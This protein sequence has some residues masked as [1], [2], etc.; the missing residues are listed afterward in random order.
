MEPLYTPLSEKDAELNEILRK[1]KPR[2]LASVSCDQA[3]Q[4]AQALKAVS[5]EDLARIR[6]LPS[7]KAPRW[8]FGVLA[9]I[10]LCVLLALLSERRHSILVWMSACLTFPGIVLFVH[11]NEHRRNIRR[12]RRAASSAPA[13]RTDKLLRGSD[14]CRR[15]RA[16]V[17]ASGR[18]LVRMDFW[19]MRRLAAQDDCGTE[20]SQTH[21]TRHQAQG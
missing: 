1:F 13:A 4:Y 11:M 12:L 21:L 9:V 5:V 18:E 7:Y 3:Q 20:P 8:V 2:R 14:A 15:Y 16:D 17:L 6:A 19:V 10:A